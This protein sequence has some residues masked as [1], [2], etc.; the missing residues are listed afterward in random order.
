MPCPWWHSRSGWMGHWATWPSCRRSCSLQGS[1]T[2]WPLRVSSKQKDSM[3]L[4]FLSRNQGSGSWTGPGKYCMCQGRF[5]WYTFFKLTVLLD[6]LSRQNQAYAGD[7]E[8][9]GEVMG[10]TVRGIIRANIRG[11]ENSDWF[12]RYMRG[13]GLFSLFFLPIC[14]Y[15]WFHTIMFGIN[16]NLFSLLVFQ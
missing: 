9:F 11:P 8:C 10:H 2:R 7:T 4:W 13:Q 5:V 6:L 15:S 3:T 12:Q 14:F 16:K 1:W